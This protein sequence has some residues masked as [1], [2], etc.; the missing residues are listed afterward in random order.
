MEFKQLFNECKKGSTTA[1]KYFY[2]QNAKAMFLICRRYLKTD[3][4]SEEA[5]LNGFLQFFTN[6]EKIDYINESATI[7][8][9]RRIMINECL[10]QIR[11]NNS[12]LHVPEDAAYDVGID[13]FA[14]SKLSAEEIFKLITSLPLG[15]RTVFNLYVIE[16]MPH[17]EIAS[18]LGI[19]EG[20]SKSQLNKAKAMLQKLINQN[21]QFYSNVKQ[22]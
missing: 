2:D 14:I 18:T 13:E 9:L 3:E 21:N 15:Y 20:T 12:V 6:L 7:G 16:G 17:K 22:Q 4:Q 11:K 19:T 1:Q 10:M 8:W 5:M